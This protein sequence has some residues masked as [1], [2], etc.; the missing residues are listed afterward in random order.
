LK[1]PEVVE[2]FKFPKR[3]F[4]PKQV[5]SKEDLK[6]FFNVLGDDRDQSFFLLAATSGLRRGELLGLAIDDLDIENRLIIPK[7]AH[8]TGT[9]KKTWVSC[10]NTEAQ[11]C[12]RRYLLN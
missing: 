2:S 11:T 6:R 7:N 5:P 4:T 10:F 12:L 3:P 8:T 1:K 9:T